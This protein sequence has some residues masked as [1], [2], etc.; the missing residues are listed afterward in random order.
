LKE[1]HLK[2]ALSQTAR[3]LPVVVAATKPACAA[4]SGS[5]AVPG[6]NGDE[7]FSHPSVLFASGLA[8]MRKLLTADQTSKGAIC[9]SLRVTVDPLMPSK[10]S[11]EGAV[12]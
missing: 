12:A 7:N 4:A 9:M 1:K 2:E 10:R 6:R 3:P 8:E 5:K 11:L